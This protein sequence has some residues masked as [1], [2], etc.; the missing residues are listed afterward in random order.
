VAPVVLQNKYACNIS[1]LF[2]FQFQDKSRPQSPTR[3]KQLP[4]PL[5]ENDPP[6]STSVP[7]KGPPPPLPKKQTSYVNV[8]QVSYLPFIVNVI[9]VIY[10]PFIVL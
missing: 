2:F 3:R 1:V 9:P 7:P 10:L 6:I 5:P 4:P 8:I